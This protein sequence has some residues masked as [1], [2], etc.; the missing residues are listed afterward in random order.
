[1]F[2]DSAAIALVPVEY[3]TNLALLGRI[4]GDRVKLE[5]WRKVDQ[6]ERQTL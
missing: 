2:R 4:R 5:S 1:M 3:H 6:S